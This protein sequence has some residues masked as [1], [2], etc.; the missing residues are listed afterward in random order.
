MLYPIELRGPA[1]DLV[2]RSVH[3]ND[4]Q[5]RLCRV[6]TGSRDRKHRLIPAIRIQGIGADDCGRF[7]MS[8]FRAP[9]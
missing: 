9:S 7:G 4:Y 5:W 8:A 1:I 6:F 2:R 3:R